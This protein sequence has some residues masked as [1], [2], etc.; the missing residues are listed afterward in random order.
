[1]KQI[2]K[3]DITL[4]WRQGFWLVYFIVSIAFLIL[5]FNIPQTHRLAVTIYILLSDTSVLGITFVGALILLEKQQNVL[6]SL[7]VTPLT[8]RKYL[9]SKTASLTLLIL[10]MGIFILIPVNPFGWHFIPILLATVLSSIIFTLLGLGISARANTINQYLGRMIA[11]SVIIP[12]PVI[13]FIMME[14]YKWLIIF[15]INAALNIMIKVVKGSI[16]SIMVVDIFILIFWSF[17]AYAYAYKE[18]KK[19]VINN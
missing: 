11:F 14:N 12:L 5:L 18:F 15:P 10:C 16:T 6:Q 9:I 1:M 2:L 19:H 13:P 8:I 3:Y 17:I 4:Q 7:F